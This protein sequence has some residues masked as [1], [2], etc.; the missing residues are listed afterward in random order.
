MSADSFYHGVEKMMKKRPGAVV[1]DIQDFKEVIAA[2]NSGRV[3]V[4]E[5]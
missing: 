2:S 4:V 1:L 5:L 3:D